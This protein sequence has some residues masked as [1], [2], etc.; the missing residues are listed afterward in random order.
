MSRKVIIDCDPGVEDAVAL[1]L[2]LFSPKLDVT[3]LTAVAG[4]V[5]AEQASR[6]IQVVIEQLDPPRFPRV[7]SALPHD[8]APVQEARR[9]SGDDGL[10][11]LSWNVSLLV[12]QHNSEKIIGDEIR[13][14]PEM[15]TILCLGPLTN[16]ARAF[17]RDPSLE[18]SVGRIIMLGGSVS[19]VGNVTPAAEFN[20]HYDPE[21]ARQI[22]RSPTT[23]T[24]I[25]LDVTRQVTFGLD[26]INEL[27][28]EQTRSGG[29]LRKLLTHAFRMYRNVYGQ[30]SLCLHAAVAVVAAMQPELFETRE[31]FGDIETHGELT[32]GATIFDRRPEYRGRATANMEVALEVDV[33]AVRDTIVRGLASIA[34]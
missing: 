25:P 14:D 29:F 23:K 12:H 6:N 18:T 2:A 24:L 22:F 9:V 31:L 4:E 19:G 27:P 32:T 28:A 17:Q 13:N 34:K 30:E 21:S 3:A 20:M 15:T 26:L 33:A 7:G 16:L 11:G 10:A 1:A 5:S 8:T